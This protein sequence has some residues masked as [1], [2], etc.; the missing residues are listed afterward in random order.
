MFQIST[1]ISTK[2]SFICNK[3]VYNKKHFILPK[4]G[5]M[6]QMI[7]RIFQMHGQGDLKIFLKNNTSEKGL[8]IFAQLIPSV[9]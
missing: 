7:L 1:E 2:I 5:T 6:S 4:E 9:K 3:N 8:P